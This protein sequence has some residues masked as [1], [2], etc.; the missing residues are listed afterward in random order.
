M[1]EIYTYTKCKS[2]N[3]YM[4]NDGKNPNFFL[5]L[6]LNFIIGIPSLNQIKISESKFNISQGCN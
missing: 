4:Q 5:S 1:L 6:L 3:I 2:Q